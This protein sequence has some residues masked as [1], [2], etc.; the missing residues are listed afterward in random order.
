MRLL[1]QAG[2]IQVVFLSLSIAQSAGPGPMMPE[3]TADRNHAARRDGTVLTGFSTVSTITFPVMH[4]MIPLS[5]PE[6]HPE[7]YRDTTGGDCH[8]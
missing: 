5:I 1:Q 4:P 8:R 3:E 7:E 2:A 6:V